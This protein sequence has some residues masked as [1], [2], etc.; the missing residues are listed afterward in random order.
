[1]L[2]LCTCVRPTRSCLKPRKVVLNALGLAG[3]GITFFGGH[4]ASS[5][6]HV[7]TLV[8]LWFALVGAELPIIKV[9]LVIIIVFFF[10]FFFLVVV[11]VCK[12]RWLWE[13]T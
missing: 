7:G 8:G 10:F 2:Y 11:L 3:L 5:Y 9:V 12:I 6:R 13:C 4:D 1:M